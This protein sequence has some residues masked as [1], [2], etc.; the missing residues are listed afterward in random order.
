[1]GPCFGLAEGDVGSQGSGERSLSVSFI[2]TYIL[3]TSYM[4]NL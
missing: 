3:V 4:E 2:T 1:M